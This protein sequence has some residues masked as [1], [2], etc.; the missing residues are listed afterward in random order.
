MSLIRRKRCF[1]KSLA[2]V[3]ALMIVLTG[4]VN[5][6]SANKDHES[7]QMLVIQHATIVDVK[8]GKLTKDQ[9]I[10]ITDNKISHIGSSDETDIPDYAKVRDAKGQYVIPGLWDMHVH[11]EENY[12]NA[13]PL[14]LANGVTGVRE[15]GAAFKNIDQW[16][17]SIQAGMVA[18]RL[19][20]A[21]MTL[22]GGPAD[23]APHMRYLK[24][25]E[26]AREAVRLNAEKGASHIKVYS[27]LPRPLFLA[28]MD[29]AKKFNLPVVGHLP[30]EVRASEAIQLGFKSI[31]HMHGLFIATS[32]MEDEIFK[33]ADMSDLLGYS[34]AEIKASSNY[35][36]KKAEKLFRSLKEKGV[37]PVP[38]LTAYLN[39]AKTEIDSRS[40][41][42]PTA[43]QESWAEIIRATP[44]EQTELVH[45][46]NSLNPTMVQKLN[47]A[48]VP[49]LAG[50]DSSYELTNMIYGVTLHDELKLL[51]QSGLTPLQALQT[52]TLNPAKYLKREQDLGTVEVGK[53]ADLV[54]LNKNPLEDIN[55]TT[56][57]SAVVLDG[58]LM[59]KQTLDQAVKT[60]PVVK[61]ADIKVKPTDPNAA[62]N[63]I[64]LHNH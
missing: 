32:S 25:E 58:K 18:P 36:P 51:V 29:E 7:K 3:M 13:F 22:N 5:S 54:L 56:T 8:S 55:N 39:M 24:T 53:L 45:V 37:W 52:A 14:L 2:G 40:K 62:S 21:G 6:N 28:V 47:D 17:T 42:V 30:V 1:K 19:L 12:K 15:M 33:T 38:T 43:V 34:T 46:I 16:N 44:P 60:Y 23:D 49:M 50:T 27:W 41:Y 11:L 59:E 4:C 48:G 35:D 57:I 9:T 10:T 20:Y 61:V 64:I 26:E 63:K 31:E